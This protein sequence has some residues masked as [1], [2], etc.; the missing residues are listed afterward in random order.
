MSRVRTKSSRERF[1]KATLAFL[2]LSWIASGGAGADLVGSWALEEG[3]GADVL[4]TSG[5]EHHGVLSRDPGNGVAWSHGQLGGALE[6]DGRGTHVRV[7]DAT[8]LESSHAVTL[9]ARIRPR[10]KATQ[11][12]VKKA[13]IRR[14]DGY[15]LALS[16]NGRVFV[17]FN[18]ASRG[19]TYKVVSKAR[20]PTDGET[21]LHI[22][23]TFDG[24]EIR[25]YLD[26]ELD[27]V[28]EA[29]GLAIEENSEPLT[30]GAEAEG[31][32][33]YDGFVEEVRIYDEAL[34]AERIVALYGDQ[35]HEQDEDP[36]DESNVAPIDPPVVSRPRSVGHWGFDHLSGTEVEDT[37]GM[38]GHGVVSGVIRREEGPVGDAVVMPDA[39]AMVTIPSA[40][41]L[42]LSQGLSLAA[43]VR[44]ER[45]ATQYILRKTQSSRDDGYELSLSS[46][47]RAFVRFNQG[48]SRNRFKVMTQAPYPTDGKT[49]QHLVATFDGDEIRLYV[50]SELD[51][52]EPAPGLVIGVNSRPL[53]LLSASGRTRGLTG[54]ADEIRIFDGALSD[55]DVQALFEGR[56]PVSAS[57]V[58][59]NDSGQSNGGA[60]GE[61]GMEPG[62]EAGSE[63]TLAGGDDASE[64]FGEQNAE[65]GGTAHP[66]TDSEEAE[67]EISTGSEQFVDSDSSDV[68]V[69][70]GDTDS[71][72]ES[73]PEVVEESN[74]AVPDPGNY[75]VGIWLFD[76]QAGATARD[77]SVWGN[78]A[79][80]RRQVDLVP[81]KV[82]SAFDLGP[83]GYLKV[84]DSASLQLSGPM[85]L[86][87]WVRPVAR[88]TQYLIKKAKYG[89]VDGYELG[90]SSSGRAF[91]RFD[92]ARSGN[93]LRV[94][95]AEMYPLDGSTW[96]HLAGV[97]DGSKI[98]LYLD[99][100]LN[101]ELPVSGFMPSSNELPL[102][103]GA[104]SDGGKRFT[105]G[106][107]EVRI[108]NRALGLS[109]LQALAEG[110][111]PV[112]LDRDGILDVVDLDDDGDGLP[113]S[114]EAYF[115]L[116]GTFA[117][118]AESD[119]DGDGLS[120]LAE[121]QHGRHPRDQDED[122]IPDAQDLFPGDPS[123]SSDLDGDGV[124][125]V[126]DPDRDGDGIP[127]DWE[128][129]FGFDPSDAS[130]AG[131]D[132]D[133]DGYNNLEEFVGDLHPWDR[134]GD[135]VADASDVFPDNP[136]E[137]ADND[138]DGIGDNSDLDDDEDGLPDLWE[139]AMAMDPWDAGD[140]SSDRD[141]DGLTASAEWHLGTST[142][143]ADSDEDGAPDGED[144]FP[145]DVAEWLDSDAD[146][147]GDNA[148]ADDDD[149][150]LP[151]VWEREMGLDSLDA[152][153]SSSDR[154]GDGL[155][156]QAELALGTSA[157]HADT[158][159]DGVDDRED[160]FPLD[161][162]DWLDA[163]ADGLG[164]NTD[165]DDDNDGLPDLWELAMGLDPL[166][167][168]D[169][170]SDLDGDGLEA[171]EEW[172]MGTSASSSDTDGDG[173]L[174]AIDVFPIDGDEWIDTDEDG[175]GNNSDPDDDGDGASDDWEVQYGL[176]PLDP[177]DAEID[178]DFDGLTN[179]EE[180]LAG[181]LPVDRDRDGVVDAADAFPEDPTEWLD[182]D[183][184][185]TGDNADTDDD[186]DGLPDFWELAMDLDPFDASDSASDLDRDG[187]DARKELEL[188][189][190][191]RVADSDGD[192]SLD[193]SDAFPLNGDEWLDIDGDGVGDNQDADDDGD[194]LPDAWE[195][196]MG[197]DPV[198]AND[199]HSD[200]DSDGLSALD[201]FVLGTSAATADTDE[202]GSRDAQDVFPLDASE[203]LDADG[204]G[205]GDNADGDDDNDGLPDSWELS[206]GLDP[207]GPEDASSDQDG[208]GLDA[209][210][211]FAMGTSARVRDSDGDGYGDPIDG[212]PVDAH[213]WLDSDS[214]G[215][216]NNADGDDD[217]DGTPD[218]WEVLYGLDPLDPRDAAMDSDFDGATN[219]QE[220]LAGTLPVDRDHDGVVD[221]RDQF[222]DDPS[223]WADNDA[224][225]NGDNGDLDDD[226]D[227]LPDAWES[228]MGLDPFDGRD[229]DSDRDGDGLNARDEWSL[230][231][232][233]QDEDSDADGVFDSVDVF[234][235]DSAEWLD[236]DGD[237][238]GNNA[239]GD[240]DG[241]GLPDAWE[242][243][244]GLDS[245]EAGDASSDSDED[246]LDAR[247]EFALGT[248][249]QRSDSDGDGATDWS[250]RFPLDGQEWL[251]SDDDGLGDNADT[252]D[253]N[254]GLPDSWELAMELDPLDGADADTDS[255][256]DG[257]DARAEWALGTAANLPDSDGDGSLDPLDVFP[258]D[259]SEWVDSDGD[260]LGDNADVD[261]DGDGIFD[262]WEILYGFDPMDPED[263]SLDS[264]FDGSTNLQEF[265]AGTLPVD[266]DQD[267][268]IDAADVFPD[269]PRES[270][271]HDGDGIGNNADEDDDGD[272]LPDGW[273]LS[274]G[275]DSLDASDAASDRDADGLDAQSEWV[276][277]TSADLP[278]TDGDGSLD[279]ED[280][281]PLDGSEWLD[282]DRDGIGNNADV[283]DDGDNLPDVW[284]LSM[285][286]DPLDSGDADSDRD[287]DGLTALVEFAM[288][289]SARKADSDGDGSQDSV[290]VFP[291]NREEW[292][293]VDGDGMGDNGDPDD[294]EDGLPDLWE[295]AMELDPFDSTDAES[296][297]DGDGLEARKEL[298]L[299]TW[300]NRAD[301]DGDGFLD[302]VDE[303][304]LNH[305]EWIDTDGDGVGNNADVD[306]DGDGISDRW[307]LIHGLDARDPDDAE[308]DSDLDGSTNL[309]EFR[310][311]TLPVDRDDDGAADA[312]DR[313]PDDPSEWADHDGDGTG[314]NEDIDDDD[315]GLPDVWE[316]AMGLDP[317]DSGD[318][319]SDLDGDGLTALDERARGTSA[320]D[321]DSDG[322]GALDRVDAFPLDFN[323]WL[324]GDGDGIGDN[325]DTDD[326]ADG[327]PDLWERAM[328][329]DPFDAGDVDSDGDSD[330]LTARFEFALGTSARN[331]DTDADGSAD[332]V[333]LF[334]LDSREWRDT[335]GDGLGDAADLDD[336][337]DGIFDHW[338]TAYGLH[339]LDPTD[340]LEDQDADGV[341]NLGEFLAGT[342]PVDRDDD[343]VVDAADE[344]PLDPF[345][346]LDTDGDGI[347]NNADSDDDADH[348]PDAWE[349]AMALDPLDPSDAT[350]DRDEDGLDARSEFSM[351]TSAL[352]PDSDGDGALD[353][354]DVFPL[355]AS[356]WLDSD[357]DGLGNNADAD[358]DDDGIP[359]DWEIA[360]GLD[361][362][363][364]TD[365][366]LDLDGDLLTSHREY[367]SGT[368]PRKADTDGD[369]ARDDTDAFALDASEWLDT[370]GD[371]I[372]DNADSDDDGDGLSDVW[373]IESGLDPWTRTELGQDPDGDGLSNSREFALGTHGGLADTDGDGISDG[374]DAL[375]HDPM[376]YAD[377]DGDGLGNR[378]DTDDDGDGIPDVW[379][380]RFGLDPLNPADASGDSNEDGVDH[381]SEFLLGLDPILL[382]RQGIRS[383]I[384]W[385]FER[386]EGARVL[387]VSGNGNDGLATDETEFSV[388]RI[389]TALDLTSTRS[390]VVGAGP[391]DLDPSRGLTVSV[392][393]K[394]RVRRTQSII[395][396]LDPDSPDGIEVAFSSAGRAFVRFNAN[397]SGNTYKIYSESP[398]PRDGETWMHL[399]TTF[400]GER[401]R[402]YVDGE[403]EVTRQAPELRLQGNGAPPRVGYGGD[404]RRHFDGDLDE[405]RIFEGVLS[406][407]DI[408]ALAQTGAL[409]QDTDR[410]GQ[411]DGEDA[412]PTNPLEWSDLDGDGLGDTQ[413]SDDDGDGISDGWERRYGLN[414]RDA[415]DGVADLDFDGVSNYQEFL[416]DTHPIGRSAA[417]ASGS[418]SFEDESRELV[419][420]SSS[421][422]ADAR[423]H[424]H[425]VSV[426]G[427]FGRA[428]RFSENGHGLVA[429][430]SGIGGGRGLSLSLWVRPERKRTQYLL[431]KATSQIDGYEISLS[432][433]GTPFFRMNSASLGNQFRVNGHQRYPTDG[434]TWMHLAATIGPDWI[435]FYVD[436]SL[437]AE[438]EA[439][440]QA[441]SV[442]DLALGIGA[443]PGGARSFVGAIDEVRIFEEVLDPIAITELF[444]LGALA[445]DSDRDG[446]SDSKDVFPDDPT[447]WSDLD[448]DG[449]G[450]RADLDADG[451]GMDD[452]WEMQ[453]GFDPY[454]GGEGAGDR[455]S[456]GLSNLGEFLRGT[457]PGVVDT[458]GDGVSD[459]L[460][461]F[462]AE[463][464]F[465]FD[466]DQDRVPDAIDADID[467]DGLPNA[468]ELAMGLDPHL[469]GDAM[470]DLDG[471]GVSNF[472][473][474][475]AGTGP[476]DADDDGVRDLADAFPLDSR[477]W[478]DLDGDGVGNNSDP[479]DDNDGIPDVWEDLNGLDSGDA[480]DAH[481]DLDFDEVTNLQEFL[482]GTLPLDRD[483]DGVMDSQDAFPE[484]ST[485]WA[486]SDLDGVGNNIDAD[487]DGD[488][489]LD[490]WEVRHELDPYDPRDA[491]LD[492]D[493]DGLDA[494]DE[495]RLGTDPRLADSDFDG[496]RDPL[497]AF[498]LDATESAD[499]DGDGM[500]NNADVDDDGDGLPDVWESGMG[501]N[502]LD[503][504]DGV[505]DSDGDGLT[506]EA[507]FAQGT[508]ARKPDSD[509]DGFLDREDLFPL[510]SAEWRDT[511]GDGSGDN[512][513]LDDDGDGLPDVWE[514]GMDLN[515]LDPIDVTLDWDGDGLNAGVEFSL[516]TSDRNTDSDADGSLD[517]E[518]AFPMAAG[519]WSDSDGDGIGDNADLDDDGDGLPDVWE[520]AMA[521]DPLDREDADSDRDGDG[522]VAQDEYELGT[523]AIVADSDADGALDGEDVFPLDSG[524]WLDTDGDGV[525]NQADDDDDDDGML[526]VWEVRYGLN[527]LDPVDAW[528]DSDFDGLT[529][530]QEFYAGT[531][532][533][534]RDQDGVVDGEDDFPND[535]MEWL[536]SDGDGV[537]DNGDRDDDGDGMPDVWE[538]AMRLDAIDPDDA[539]SD[540][541][542]DG[543][544]A[545]TEYEMGT[546]ARF[547]DSDHDG[548]SDLVDRFP[549]DANEWA[550]LDADGVGNNS[551]SD[552]DGDG[553]PDAWELAMG[554]DPLDAGDAGSDSDGDGLDAYAEFAAGTSDQSADSDSDGTPDA[555]DAFPSNPGEWVDLDMDGIGNNSDLDDDGDGLPDTWE[556]SM[557]M[558]PLDPSDVGLDSDS[559]G[560]DARTE[561][562]SGTS[563]RSVDSDGDGLPDGVD[564]FP[565]D[566]LEWAD[567]DADGLGDNSDLDDDGDGIFDTWELQYG[568]DPLDPSDSG[569]D[570]DLDGATNLEEFLAGTSPVDRDQ[571]GVGDVL[572]V[573][574]DDPSEWA[575]HD[576]DGLGDQADLDDDGDGLPD[577]WE[578]SMGLDP[579]DLTDASSDRDEDGLSARVE[580]ALGTSA[581]AEDTDGDG[582]S[583][584]EDLFPLDVAE[585]FDH[586]GD[587]VGNG[588]DEDDDGDGMPDRWELLYG[589]MPLDP[590]DAAHDPDG[591]G[592]SNLDEYR[593]GEHPTLSMHIALAH[594]SF[595]E[596]PGGPVLDATGNGF[597]GILEGTA[598]YLAGPH[599]LSLHLLGDG[600]RVTVPNS[601]QL[602]VLEGLT[603]SAWVRPEVR[604]SQAIIRKME[605]HT[606]DGF[607]LS[608][609]SRGVPFV[610]LNQASYG[611]LYKV[612]GQT[613]YPTQ[614]D[615]WMHLAATFDGTA[616]RMYVNGRLESEEEAKGLKIAS[617]LL[618]LSVGAQ[619]DGSASFQGRLDEVYVF[620]RALGQEQVTNLMLAGGR[621]ADSD[622]DTVPDLLDL[623]PDDALEWVDADG[624]GVGDAADPD[625]DED[626]MLDEW[627]LAHGFD[628]LD[629]SDAGAD[630]DDDGW[631]NFDEFVSQGNPHDLQGPAVTL[632]TDQDG[633]PDS[634]ERFYGLD[635]LGS[636]D[637]HLDLDFDGVSNLEEWFLG[638]D[639]M[640]SG[641]GPELEDYYVRRGTG[642]LQEY[643]LCG[644]E[645]QPFDDIDQCASVLT[646]G[647]TC[648]V[649][650]G[651]YTRGIDRDDGRPYQP[652]NSG[653]PEHPIR[654]AAYPGHRPLIRDAAGV[655]WNFGVG[656]RRE[657][658]T[659]S[660]F[661]VEGVVRIAGSHEEARS[662]GIVVEDFEIC[663]GGG[664]DD[665]N[666]SG[667]FAEYVEDLTVRESVVRSVRSP[668]GGRQK[669]MTLF[670]S[671]RAL[672]ENSFFF[673]NTSEGIFD[674]QGGEYNVYR[675][676]AFQDNGVG[677][678]I[679][680]QSSSIGIDNVGTEIYENVFF[681]TG[682][683]AGESV[684]ML[685]EPTDWSVY[686]N[687]FHDCNGVVIR[688]LSGPATGGEIY[689]N[690]WSRKHKESPK[691]F[692]SWSDDDREPEF[693][694]FNLFGV[695]GRFEENR[696]VPGDREYESLAEWSSAAHPRIYDTNSF[697]G[698][699]R[700]V[701]ARNGDFRLSED[702]HARGAGVG[703]E[704]IGAYPRADHTAVGRVRG[705]RISNDGGECFPLLHS[706]MSAESVEP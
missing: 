478:A 612:Y 642:C 355:D 398:Y 63:S 259:G 197:L 631:T 660:G 254:D 486:D 213:E 527:P 67:G 597:D 458:D 482:A 8:R 381:S 543:L 392:W 423:I 356:E 387:D 76:N 556:S 216:G 339:P 426:P 359:D 425:S 363:D 272:G 676:N 137:W 466:L 433:S 513:D 38:E 662:R 300:A 329:L 604:D 585:W 598:T 352:R 238:V 290:D 58:A 24:D 140:A 365:G 215:V 93:A 374:L 186:D 81:G 408:R 72:G 194:G 118:D 457:L 583:D 484:D 673:D 142:L 39:D 535:P 481:V 181:T 224:D 453:W 571:D 311:G 54:A 412:F 684:R 505:S 396:I 504:G 154:D 64:G 199:A 223:E 377:S 107:D 228:A 577:S 603:L 480:S 171:R 42:D 434:R 321:S 77:S 669:G 279:L 579:L 16:S 608:L 561:F 85:T 288:G 44:P 414:E 409:S 315:D 84:E 357:G 116:D 558:D 395:E 378:S 25:L 305:D 634:F 537:G 298:E 376:E 470:T 134:D 699:A 410:D 438:L 358:D 501:L 559:D 342:L 592:V 528:T 477:E 23:A 122:G 307:E 656:E 431:K 547:A 94:D 322:D 645:D 657:Y 638:T 66:G 19:N 74:S 293:D 110:S 120:N 284:E 221:G 71:V 383:V 90:L 28:E 618:P 539:D 113:D 333:D 309:E 371:G 650:D 553:L 653:T 488:G 472:D 275:L 331:S 261:D 636:F 340:A 542:G 686:N 291:L 593:K 448:G 218:T 435:R 251:D 202:D 580:Y 62:V 442:N 670:D 282:T 459:S 327:L 416:N 191:A 150:G 236:T 393:A 151:D 303:F 405:V 170:G 348:L 680:N 391:L 401:V 436:G 200:G 615:R 456:D 463:A 234:P 644:T 232:S 320:Q 563:D 229:A 675:R 413:D 591:D 31:V 469:R 447:E 440:G 596:G 308:V 328:G 132:S 402:I 467:G 52:V 121:Y 247:A 17:R 526:D 406:S 581:R 78:H 665:G 417:V 253:D 512:G 498:P 578:L 108:F 29:S 368:H 500:G 373:E 139:L 312:L 34:T 483:R 302:P 362:Q 503:P 702:S 664:K 335:D 174:D 674:K 649:M 109:E 98:S 22:A 164:D 6:F 546:S 220:F 124:G 97:F 226:N 294:D 641:A 14:S 192:G 568:F 666:W 349:W 203:W 427:V 572:D 91:V 271:D 701:D 522:L 161:G 32:G 143:R 445:V 441:V 693:M 88:K 495:W 449:V 639:P 617:N 521:L 123:E 613:R 439:S 419:P 147:V 651:I 59:E 106:L 256:G 241:D 35:S 350:S 557:R 625:D 497:D 292:S 7:S 304:P 529:N 454:A 344:F 50:D 347:G 103:I 263:S 165:A 652:V 411:P 530:R 450:D 13:R 255:D 705:N 601:T 80:V 369:A 366:S 600:A 274:M 287:S 364:A 694:D 444:E 159:S 26:G 545:R 201:E 628:P 41:P 620:D 474:Y 361:S 672:V 586:D 278:D 460:D 394:T 104:E 663:R 689:N 515:P 599:G 489:L 544:S 345:E 492:A 623:F 627:E 281:F 677:L 61:S 37:S 464:A 691:W 99:G 129:T 386:V 517:S 354:V 451:D 310:A 179:L 301:S 494:T 624:D 95:S 388:G 502:P 264:D 520:M 506:A 432:S 231:T 55:E 180:F 198:N 635:P 11:Y 100:E 681:C 127:N 400:D 83:G 207:F 648:W 688:S 548:R 184:D 40:S 511:D 188:G 314:D 269:D 538:I 619:F 131:F 119:L 4:D 346:S 685:S 53:L 524:E 230:G 126:A 193:G 540:H 172:V 607:E 476:R 446:E 704:D 176:D 421:F 9:V 239:D 283:D 260:G 43:W 622:G 389:G 149:D 326:D 683:S 602:G 243:A 162:R 146:G 397:R 204:D 130:D 437:D 148:D 210:A 455:D 173:S 343:G 646:A 227:G 265:L 5:W 430:H 614:G 564:V 18:Q 196:A 360:H 536:D 237:T 629:P 178:S 594:W 499:F 630:A 655:V 69:E 79:S 92:Q 248:S 225:G 136:R 523:S 306:D 611:N 647:Q 518:D 351:G 507:E 338:E 36:E 297:A 534:D 372:G 531:L 87:V 244:M 47:G 56:E 679:N 252:D 125:D 117:G 86:S 407:E 273:E 661:R 167:S 525:G 21:P 514:L 20:Y 219:L 609:S 485:E 145:L 276:L 242:L 429:S 101:G 10:S 590:S 163:D 158:D 595:D 3:Q 532:P 584:A 240:D 510:D 175:V 319:D 390:G 313:F 555:A 695:G 212:F 49:W 153:D 337:G 380:L 610:R 330:G 112:D 267:G 570:S 700:F 325:A 65:N 491:A 70:T 323:E 385:D 575:D 698:E 560:L 541:D 135:R 168:G 211:E 189:T 606:T 205:F 496:T 640:E 138:G 182:N 668:S 587:G 379:E 27:Q 658:I 280:V 316:L 257:L 576:G 51:S 422:G 509:G 33:A 30:I 549:R 195:S 299:G 516:G 703:G 270:F 569:L 89:K 324:D 156:A 616:I 233:A 550:D 48:S 160:R 82:G 493:A 190:S 404:A 687:V 574:P 185:G 415:G 552:G 245:L 105:G 370:D 222:P 102:A 667:I 706:S 289:T 692:E 2:M 428:L 155:D 479:D 452:D 246:G 418:W 589:L 115:G 605:R 566:P 258:L 375:P 15:E 73:I 183:G 462:P 643:P 621:I 475:V 399:A 659:F 678:K 573:F 465:A 111:G 490:V 682:D 46:T 443:D 318:A 60:G 696:Y 187:L 268:V 626:G 632:D 367:L 334:P 554:L 114:W 57:A 487:D 295:L 96:L 565:A 332:G 152:T 177:G 336:D 214:D 508:S 217:G 317:F 12:L 353:R 519:E 633:M 206:M 533:V 249:A 697:E 75:A 208:D 157:L 141:G 420:D 285:E 144:I 562:A 277:G 690:I 341:N 250:D 128:L 473:E 551:D 169:A 266:R 166:A 286:L 45:K 567:L 588:A 424:G 468:W 471:D 582:V 671:R 296:D 384:H 1:A 209:R 235:L 133:G 68:V 403:L 637:A 382:V 654:I 461:A 262:A